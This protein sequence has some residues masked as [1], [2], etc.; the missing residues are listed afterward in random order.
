MTKPQMVVLSFP[1]PWRVEALHSD[2]VL[3][4]ALLRRGGAPIFHK[5]SSVIVKEGLAL[6]DLVNK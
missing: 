1:S 2:W 5:A 6:L 4:A 3:A